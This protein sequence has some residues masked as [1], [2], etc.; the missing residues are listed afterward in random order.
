MQVFFFFLKYSNKSKQIYN[1]EKLQQQKKEKRSKI[2]IVCHHLFLNEE[3]LRIESYYRN[4]RYIHYDIQK[5]KEKKC[6]NQ[7]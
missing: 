3:L 4:D 6:P 5:L 7:R 2:K 1:F